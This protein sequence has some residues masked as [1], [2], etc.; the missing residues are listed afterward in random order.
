MMVSPHNQTPIEGLDNIARYICRVYCPS[1][2]EDLGPEVASV[3]DSWLDRFCHNFLVTSAKERASIVKNLNVSLGSNAWV[4]GNQFTLADLVLYCVI[5]QNSSG[6]KTIG[7]NV[8][9]W[10]K[11]CRKHPLLVNI[12]VC[13]I[14][15]YPT[16]T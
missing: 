7:A 12:P 14:F 13:Q 5:S 6:L 8:E 15:A 11:D 1:L 3:I 16:H 10:M 9:R 2:Y 4:V